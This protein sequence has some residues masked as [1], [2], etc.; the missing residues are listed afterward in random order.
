MVKRK[1][2]DY[3]ITDDSDVVIFGSDKII[4][5]L[6]DTGSCLLYEPLRVNTSKLKGLCIDHFHK[7]KEKLKNKMKMKKSYSKSCNIIIH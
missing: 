5:K 6:Q 1:Y 7:R 4:S 3:A 2:V